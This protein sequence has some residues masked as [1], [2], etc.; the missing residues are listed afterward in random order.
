[1]I[2]KLQI[3]CKQE[4]L[5]IKEKLSKGLTFVFIRRIYRYIRIQYIHRLAPWKVCVQYASC[6]L[7]IC[8]QSL[9]CTNMS[10]KI[11]TVGNVF[12]R[13]EDEKIPKIDSY[14]RYTQHLNPR[15]ELKNSCTH[16]RGIEQLGNHK[17]EPILRR[18]FMVTQ[19][20]LKVFWQ[21]RNLKL[22]S[23]ILL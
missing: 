17:M 19:T 18:G 21:I 12:W 8:V 7:C 20:S 1:M 15:H 10:S 9:Q 13:S 2:G 4:S 22:T 5:T 6:E 23:D 16:L 14:I 3:P 11:T